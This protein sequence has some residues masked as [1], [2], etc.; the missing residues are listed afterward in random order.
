[1]SYFE[2]IVA[3]F[4]T[5]RVLVIGDFILDQYIWGNVDRI[6]PEAPVPVVDIDSSRHLLGGAANVAANVRA[7]GD[8]PLLVGVV[9][10]DDAA[11]RLMK[12]RPD[13]GYYLGLG[14]KLPPLTLAIMDF[15]TKWVEVIH[16][17]S[18]TLKDVINFIG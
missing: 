3:S 17:K 6:S 18:V 14:P 7:L 2:Q 16:M 15:F 11:E 12:A 9:G 13:L 1:M 8:E 4:P 10:E 5:K